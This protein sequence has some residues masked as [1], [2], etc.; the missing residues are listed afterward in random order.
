MKNMC[1]RLV[2]I[3]KPI[4]A[5]I[6]FFSILALLQ[7][8]DISIFMNFGK[9]PGGEEIFADLVKT[10]S[11]LHFYINI[12]SSLIRVYIGF[13]YAS[14]VAI[15]LAFLVTQSCICKNYLYPIMELLRPIP[16]AAWIPLAILLIHSIEGSVIFIIFLSAF[17][18][19]FVNTVKGIENVHSNYIKTAKSLGCTRCAYILEILLP[20]ALPSIFAGLFLGMSGAWL[21]VVMAEMINGQSGIGYMIWSSYTLVNTSEVIIGMFTIGSMGALSSLALKIFSNR[22]TCWMPNE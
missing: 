2:D 11:D 7:Y 9:L 20:A 12:M 15:P 10:I 22:I 17:F 13:I 18:P 19:I 8:F 21:G 1:L 4:V 5:I 14:I 3:A 16:N 6:I